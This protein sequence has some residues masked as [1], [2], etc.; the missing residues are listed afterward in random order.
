MSSHSPDGE[1]TGPPSEERSTERAVVD[2]VLEA[3]IGNRACQVAMF[4]LSVEGCKVETADGEI[5]AGEDIAFTLPGEHPVTG[6]LVWT[7]DG[8][9]G[10]FF[11]QPLHEA[12]VAHLKFKP[13]PEL[14]ELRD[15][16]GRTLPTGQRKA[17]PG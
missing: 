4:D 7:Q 1:R 6:R 11:D 16:F 10:V 14:R 15:R 2:L 17:P 13:A 3:V 12:L 9:A 8:Y 5:T